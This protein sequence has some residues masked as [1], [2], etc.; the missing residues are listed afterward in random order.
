[1]DDKK[2]NQEQENEQPVVASTGPVTLE[3]V[4]RA[5]GDMS[6]H[7]TN[8]NRLRAILRRG[9]FTT[10][11]KHLDTLR[12]QRIAAAQPAAEQSAPKAPAEAVEMLWAAAW[13]AAQAKTMGRLE[14]LSAER[15]GL[16]AK[17]QAQGADIASLVE[18]L[19]TLEASLQSQA[20]A[21]KAAQESALAEAQS[22]K[23]E[24]QV[25]AD[26]LAETRAELAKA[27]S[28]AERAV[29]VAAATLAKAQSDAEHAAALAV[30]DAQI[31]RQTMQHTIERL[32]E[33]LSESKAL[34]IANA[35]QQVK[36]AP[37][38]AP[39]TTDDKGNA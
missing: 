4:S 6:P 30:R 24:L 8:A 10:V 14:S 26:V 33:Q 35:M 27:H 32:T 22:A 36:P 1:M 17:S 19:D 12:A 28:D 16:V 13:N 34:H 20:E 2:S 21:L 7:D 5:L 3:D 15:D 18:Q 23:D 37:Q 38:S 39:N 25:Q 31:E 11:Q 9:S 29:Q